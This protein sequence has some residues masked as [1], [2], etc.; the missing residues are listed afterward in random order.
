MS[1]F[2]SG[3][4]QRALG[5]GASL[6]KAV[7]HLGISKVSERA[8]PAL[9]YS[10]RV[11][12][13]SEIVKSMGEL[14][15]A[16]MKLGQML[17]VTDDLV[18]PPEISALFRSLQRD[19]RRMSAQELGEMFQQEFGRAASEL[20]ASFGENAIAAASIGQVHQASLKSG[21]LVA[22]KVQYPAIEKAIEAD[23]KNLDKL[24]DFVS[25]LVPGKPDVE[26]LILELRDALVKEC[27][28]LQEAQSM[29]RFR[30]DYQDVFKNV[31]IPKVYEEFSSRHI[32]TSEFVHGLSFEEA[33][34]MSQSERDEICQTLYDMHMFG[35]YEKRLLHTDPQNGN[36]LFRPGEIILLDFG[37][38][39]EFSAEFIRSYV[40]LLNA[41]EIDDYQLYEKHGHNL[42]LFM[43][44]DT[45]DL[46][47]RHFEMI[48][49]LYL[50]YTRQGRFAVPDHNPFEL[51]KDFVGGM[52]IKGRKGPMPEFLLLDRANL[53]FYTK[54]RKLGGRIDWT[55]SRDK[56]RAKW[57][58]D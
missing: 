28:Y 22:V 17:S 46:K 32:I 16:L 57:L 23:F 21:E 53:G 34:E 10:R 20:F 54:I 55:T 33:L 35:L 11:K 25:L 45:L 58:D 38:T 24:H 37:S 7:A 47:E 52:S 30:Q 27:D 19:S 26:A 48:K 50:P 15:G 1:K 42:G 31:T 56:Y 12:A 3:R 18:L 44:G 6:T 51:L 9:A 40:R 43:N 13:A 39:R 5:V 41:V 49:K 29:K 2:K 8:G 36:Y 4:F 14:K